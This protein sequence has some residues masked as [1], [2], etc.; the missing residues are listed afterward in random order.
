MTN[1]DMP[2]VIDR[3]L[4]AANARDWTTVAQCFTAQADCLNLG[5]VVAHGPTGIADHLRA[6]FDRFAEHRDEITRVVV[7]GSLAYVEVALHGRT[8][9]GTAV[10]FPGADVF[11]LTP[12]RT[13]IDRVSAWFDTSRTPGR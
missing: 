11:E 7:D 10:D 6:V 3:Y 1:Q 5:V 13:A 2:P 9:D 4:A 8:H 12:D